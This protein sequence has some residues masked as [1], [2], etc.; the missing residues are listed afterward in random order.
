[1]ITCETKSITLLAS[2]FK[3]IAQRNVTAKQVAGFISKEPAQLSEKAI[4]QISCQLEQRCRDVE[5]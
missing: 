4:L 2:Q 1:M 3:T 5:F